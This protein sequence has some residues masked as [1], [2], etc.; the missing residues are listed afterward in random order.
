MSHSRPLQSN[1]DGTARRFK[2]NR[3][4]DLGRELLEI[5]LIP[6]LT[7]LPY[8]RLEWRRGKWRLPFKISSL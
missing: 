3:P 5:N 2:A 6:M 7:A 4:I 8:L 1:D